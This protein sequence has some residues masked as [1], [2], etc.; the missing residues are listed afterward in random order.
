MMWTDGWR[1]REGK[2]GYGEEWSGVDMLSWG[3]NAKAID[4]TE[5]I[6]P[7]AVHLSGRV[8]LVSIIYR[9]PNHKVERQKRDRFC[10]G[11]IT[12]IPTTADS[13]NGTCARVH[14]TPFKVRFSL[15]D[16]FTSI[17]DRKQDLLQFKRHR[18]QRHK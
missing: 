3:Q 4:G 7:A 15:D 16:F 11:G 9:A 5:R 17:D 6:F 1:T 10:G 18:V 8:C 13:P 12:T 14:F 2:I